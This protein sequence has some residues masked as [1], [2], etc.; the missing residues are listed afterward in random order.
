MTNLETTKFETPLH[1]R[2]DYNININ[3][4]LLQL[5]PITLR[6][7]YQ[8]HWNENCKDFVCL[9]RNGKLVN[10]SLYRVGGMGTPK[11]NTDNY[12]LLLKYTEAFYEDSI[13]KNKDEK[14]HLEGCWC[15]LDKNGIEK[16]KFSNFK[17]PYL[18]KNSCIYSLNNYYYNI[19]TGECYGSSYTS[20]ESTD[21]LFLDNRYSKDES[22]MGVMKINK[23]DGTYE[24]FR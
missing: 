20:I 18:T 7:D 23:K 8:K 1:A 12:F 4:N 11:L 13:T 21:Y 24:I 10:D 3:D 14:R 5:S 16:M 9:T 19:E 2:A 22:K 15:I 6:E 17:S